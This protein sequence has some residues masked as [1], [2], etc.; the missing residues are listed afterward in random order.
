MSPPQRQTRRG[1]S[2]CSDARGQSPAGARFRNRRPDPVEVNPGSPASGAATPNLLA[3]STALTPLAAP[4]M[5]TV[6]RTRCTPT[7]GRA[8]AAVLG[9]ATPVRARGAMPAPVRAERADWVILARSAEEERASFGT[10]S[11]SSSYEVSM[12]GA[13]SSNSFASASTAQTPRLRVTPV[14]TLRSQISFREDADRCACCLKDDFWLLTDA[15][16]AMDRRGVGA[17]C[18]ADFAW[19]L[20]AAAC[21]SGVE[22][23]RAARK[24]GLTAHFRKTTEELSLDAFIRRAFPTAADHEVEKMHHWVQLR[25]AKRLL[26]ASD[27]EATETCMAKVFALL[28]EGACG[29]VAASELVGARLLSRSEV[30]QLGLPARVEFMEF[31]VALLP[32]YC[33]SDEAAAEDMN[34]VWRESVRMMFRDAPGAVRK[35]LPGVPRYVPAAEAARECESGDCATSSVS[36]SHAAALAGA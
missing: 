26:T 13:Y 4:P 1:A 18:R 7:M 24:A 11:S 19:A 27:F 9:G 22:L 17:I 21:T 33:T 16:D 25:R 14:A 32:K 5:L 15:F 34:S 3:F 30:F 12:D 23:F 31:C 8:G 29:S 2:L 28:D 20:T 6:R 35:Q 36:L 10:S